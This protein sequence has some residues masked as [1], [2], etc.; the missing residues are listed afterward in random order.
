MA[1]PERA[2]LFAPPG[3]SLPAAALFGLHNVERAALALLRVGVT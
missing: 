3:S 1:R 2:I